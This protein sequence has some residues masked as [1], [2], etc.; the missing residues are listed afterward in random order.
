MP[1]YI[2]LLTDFSFKRVFGT[3]PNKDLL[4]AFSNEVFRG[5]KEIKDLVYSK[6]SLRILLPI[7]VVLI[8]FI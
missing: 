2:D 6:R 4:I 7:C 8:A 1:K 3:D 5:R